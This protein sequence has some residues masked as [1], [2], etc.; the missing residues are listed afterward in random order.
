MSSLYT[1]PATKNDKNLHRANSWK[2]SETTNDDEAHANRNL[3][4]NAMVLV[5]SWYQNLSRLGP[6]ALV[7]RWEVFKSAREVYVMVLN[8]EQSASIDVN[9]VAAHHFKIILTIVA[10]LKRE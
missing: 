7:E 10:H 1:A 4:Q 3:Q 8:L 2:P 5:G 9:K 6:W